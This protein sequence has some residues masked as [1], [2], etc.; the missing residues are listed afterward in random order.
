MTI[1][2]VIEKAIE[3]G[4]KSPC[5]SGGVKLAEHL[6]ENAN[7]VFLDPSFWQ[8][9]GKTMERKGFPDGKKYKINGRIVERRE[10][11]KRWHRFVD[12]LAEGKSA[13]SFFE[14]LK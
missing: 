8:C 3:G 13:E 9:L 1:K 4:Y 5:C 14:N 7:M 11:R 6:E 2:E 12:T 10:W